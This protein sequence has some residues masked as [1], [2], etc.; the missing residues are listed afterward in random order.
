MLSIF[1]LENLKGRDHSKGLGVGLVGGCRL[2]S[3][4]SG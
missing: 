3:A 2:D 4:G 1:W